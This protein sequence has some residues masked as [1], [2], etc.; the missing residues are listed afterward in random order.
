MNVAI[1][2]LKNAQ[3]DALI[4]ECWVRAGLENPP[5]L[6]TAACSR[7]NYSLGCSGVGG[8]REVSEVALG[9]VTVK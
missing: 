3:Q 4:G 1:S 6:G 5:R 2:N 7:V 9:N 8:Q